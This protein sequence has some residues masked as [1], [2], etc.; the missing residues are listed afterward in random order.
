MY[1]ETSSLARASSGEQQR[2]LKLNA[3]RQGDAP[4]LVS[5][6]RTALGSVKGD[7]HT[8]KFGTFHQNASGSNALT[9]RTRR[10]RL[11]LP[12]MYK[13]NNPPVTKSSSVQEG[14]P[15]RAAERC[16]L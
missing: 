13:S 6:A 8:A 5:F 3:N 1:S 4:G 16:L 11:V 15:T 14:V 12:K 7:V 9:S 10:V 2:P